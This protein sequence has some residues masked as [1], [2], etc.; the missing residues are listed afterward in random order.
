MEFRLKAVTGGRM[1][2][3]AAL[4]ALTLCLALAAASAQSNVSEK[5]DIAIFSLGYYGFI[6]PLEAL[7]GIDQELQKVF[8][9]LG[10][11]NIIGVEQRLS[12]GGLSQFIEAIRKAKEAGFV[13]PEVYRF[14]EAALTEA[15]FNKLL[16]AFI[17]AVPVISGF[18]VSYDQMK[19]EWDSEVEV[20]VTFIDVA[21]G[22]AVGVA[23][24]SSSGSDKT[25]QLKSMRSAIEG[26][27]VQLQFQIRS[28][29]AFQIN[30]R[31][32]AAERGEIVVQLGRNMGIQKGDEYAVISGGS[33]E[34]FKLDREIGLVLIKEVGAEASTGVVLFSAGRIAK[35]AQLREIPRLGVDV[36][37]YI[38]VLT[39]N[40]ATFVPGAR[41][42]LSRGFFGFRPFAAAQIPLGEVWQ[43]F[44]VTVIPVSVVLGGE[45]DLR[46]G[47]LTLGPYAG[48]GITYLRVTEATTD[49]AKDTNLF[50]HV[51]AQAYLRLSYLLTRDI[52]LFFEGGAEGWLSVNRHF[53]TYGGLG[54]GAGVA[55]KL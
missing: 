41:V 33:V 22:S 48:A 9:D 45:L 47:R 34:G 43:A 16:G 13:I 12:S 38:H 55:I 8:V 50:P 10:R 39:G 4:A 44:T 53:P 40:A 2:R 20:K 26:I 7:G 35:D 17:V 23:E 32:L 19:A 30:T 3:R 46:L 27:P 54:I 11:F 36:E 15:V 14:G 49:Y 21:S 29:P 25:D 18:N 37:P 6:I 24:V 28:M 5:K 51:G 52:R 42:I 1:K 31:V